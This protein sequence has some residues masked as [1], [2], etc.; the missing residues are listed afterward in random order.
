MRFPQEALGDGGIARADTQLLAPGGSGCPVRIS[1]SQRWAVFLQEAITAVFRLVSKLP[2]VHR[3]PSFQRDA[4][5][6][7][8]CTHLYPSGVVVRVK[9]FGNSGRKGSKQQGKRQY[10]QPNEGRILGQ[11]Q[12]SASL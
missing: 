4:L 6:A 7:I 10:P 5:R 8:Y 11:L 1:G 2:C 9:E 3:Q 12:P